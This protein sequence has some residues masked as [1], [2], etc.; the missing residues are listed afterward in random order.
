MSISKKHKQ[1]QDKI[2]DAILT[3][4]DLVTALNVAEMYFLKRVNL[5]KQ[6]LIKLKEEIA[7]LLKEIQ[8]D[9]NKKGY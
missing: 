3:I 5:V 9:N 7:K 6:R 4:I 1:V 2:E 8:E